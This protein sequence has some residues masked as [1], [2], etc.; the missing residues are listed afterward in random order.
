MDTNHHVDQEKHEGIQ[1]GTVGRGTS[2]LLGVLTAT[3]VIAGVAVL[4]AIACLLTIP[5][6]GPPPGNPWAASILYFLAPGL[7]IPFSLW[8]ASRAGAYWL[9]ENGEWFWPAGNQLAIRIGISLAF[10][11]V[12]LAACMA[13]LAPFEDFM[14]GSW[15]KAGDLF[16]GAFAA[17]LFLAILV[18][19]V[20][21]A[22]IVAGWKGVPAA[23]LLSA[24]FG[25]LCIY[26]LTD[27]NGWEMVAYTSLAASVAWFFVVGVE[28]GW[29]AGFHCGMLGHWLT[30]VLAAAAV[31]A[32]VWTGVGFLAVAGLC[33]LA[34]WIPLQLPRT[35]GVSRPAPE[36][37][38][39]VESARENLQRQQRAS[40][41]YEKKQRSRQKR[42]RRQRS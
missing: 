8:M 11:M 36:K 31:A 6:L 30:G 40:G 18:S 39:P 21:G 38:Q 27:E 37:R 34:A 14:P 3:W 10:V 35:G 2:A 29:L 28:T 23:L 4:A 15:D 20:S 16:V 19:A 26:A 22:A 42:T 7:L 9:D 32:A 13:G 33:V 25:S 17:L 24:G 41:R 12:G 1:A 5:V